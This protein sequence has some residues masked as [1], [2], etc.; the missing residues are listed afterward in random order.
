M[1]SREN[2]ISP[3]AWARI[4]GVLYLI[5]IAAGVGGELLVRDRLIVPGDATATSENIRSF[6]LLWR[7]AIAANLFHL[8]C[9]VALGLVFYVLLRRVDRDL[10]LLAVLFNIVCIAIEAISKVFLLPSLFVLGKAAYL[11][12]FTPEQLHALAYLSN[13][14]HTVGFNVSLIFFGWECLVLGYLISRSRFLPRALGVLM[15]VA[16]AAYLTNSFAVLLAPGLANIALL[17]P[18]FVAELL[19]ALWLLVKGVDERQWH[20]DPADPPTSSRGS[21]A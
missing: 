20:A 6:E 11:Q 1:T 21:S 14:S 16:G 12:A 2:E 5:V 19:L 4:G 15:L 3:Q 17:F 10:A 8:A 9:A 7:L 18:A 13:R